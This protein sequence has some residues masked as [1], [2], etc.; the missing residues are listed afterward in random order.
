MAYAFTKDFMRVD[1]GLM[2]M[3]PPIFMH[4]REEGMHFLRDRQKLME[5]YFCDTKQFTND[6]REVVK[7]NEDCLA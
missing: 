7:L 4:V 6:F 3:R 1:V 5:E 2:I